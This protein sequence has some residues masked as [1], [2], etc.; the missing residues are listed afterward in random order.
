MALMSFNILNKKLI[1]ASMIIIH[2]KQEVPRG[3]EKPFFK[4]TTSQPEVG[5]INIRK[6]DFATTI[7][8]IVYRK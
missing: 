4:N 6:S 2:L 1:F 5:M 8:I 3:K 7:V